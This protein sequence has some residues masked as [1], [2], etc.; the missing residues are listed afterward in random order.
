MDKEDIRE[1]GAM[2]RLLI[3]HKHME[4]WPVIERRINDHHLTKAQE[5]LAHS[6]TNDR[7]DA[8]TRVTIK[9]H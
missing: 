3:K 8:V 9:I 7:V 4:I 5:V 2:H 1:V 6:V